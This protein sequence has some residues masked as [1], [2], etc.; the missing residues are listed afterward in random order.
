M[1][2]N[3]AT[4]IANKIKDV[5]GRICHGGE[6]SYEEVLSML[7]QLCLDVETVATDRAATERIKRL[8][9]SL[10]KSEE[11]REEYMAQCKSMIDLLNSDDHVDRDIAMESI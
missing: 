3:S 7:N 9:D 10:N 2:D 6:L 1:P 5:A 4:Q 11:R 8:R